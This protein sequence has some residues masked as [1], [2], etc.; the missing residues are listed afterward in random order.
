MESESTNSDVLVLS[1]TFTSL[2]VSGAAVHQL[3]LLPPPENDIDGIDFF[4]F[5]LGDIISIIPKF[6]LRKKFLA[7]WREVTQMV[8][9][10]IMPFEARCRDQPI[11]Y[12]SYVI[13]LSQP[14]VDC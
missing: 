12:T 1:A 5:D 2:K 9:L 14:S 4:N 10:L 7:T 3:N 13:F 11:S 6:K 8:S